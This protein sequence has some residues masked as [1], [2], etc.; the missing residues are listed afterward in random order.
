MKNF[1]RPIAVFAML[2][3]AYGSVVAQD[4]RFSQY[5]ASPLTLNPAMTGAFSGNYRISAIYRSQWHSILK[6]D[7]P[8]GTPMFSTFSGA[9]DVRL[10]IGKLDGIGVGLAFLTDKAGAS[11]FGTNQLNLSV[12][13]NKGF[14]NLGSHNVALGFQAGGAVR[15][16]NYNNLRWGNQFDGNGFN[17][18]LN[19][20]E[21]NIKQNFWFFDI[22]VGAFYYYVD[23]RTSV[24]GRKNA[25]IGIAVDH[26]NRPNQSFYGG[27]APLYMKYVVSGGGGVPLG[28][29][30]DLQ[31]SFMF[32][33]QGPAL[34][35][36]LGTYV[37][38]FF[39]QN[40]PQG[41]AFYIGP[42]YRIVTRDNVTAKGGIASDALV[43]ATKL[44]YLSFTAGFSFDLNL[45]SLTPATNT[46]GAFEISLAH[47]GSWKKDNKVFICPRF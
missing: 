34:E 25:Y 40:Q 37:K 5:N 43:L 4:S 30:I 46:N 11:Q 20:G 15:G 12:A 16:I 6:A 2:V 38:I 21:T 19:S 36:D 29:M 1:Y 8:S 41:N 18:V 47:V 33:K 7:D 9:F 23:K 14:G 39:Q 32:M 24:K 10:P 35:T 28:R 3:L 27:S 31:P 44:D 42:W 45:S 17:E 26:L 13:Y 22:N